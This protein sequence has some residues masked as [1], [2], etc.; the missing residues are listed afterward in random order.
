MLVG[1]AA[2]RA[3]RGAGVREVAGVAGESFLPL[4]EGL[5][6]ESVP[7]VHT[8]HESGAVFYAIG[9]ARIEGTPG[10]VAVT[11]GP[12]A[13]NAMIGIHEAYQSQTPLVLLVGQVEGR[14]RGRNVIQEMDIVHMFSRAAKATFEVPTP[15]R[16]APSLL[17]ALRTAQS[18]RPGP[19]VVSLP[20]DHL[21]A[22][23]DEVT[24]P[25][26]LTRPLEF[27]ALLPDATAA[28]I[29]VAMAAARSG[30]LVAGQRFGG[31]RE[32]DLLARAAA[33][34]GFGVVGGH[35]HIDVVDQQDPHWLSGA[36]VRS[37][38]FV[39][40]ALSE[41]D[42]VLL[43]GHS[44][45]D[46][47]SQG[48]ADI[49]GRIVS[50]GTGEFAT[51]DEYL[52][53]EAHLADPV[54]ALRQ[55]LSAFPAES[56]AR[57]ARDR[58]V[59]GLRDELTAERELVMGRNRTEAERG[60]PL[61]TVVDSLD[62]HLPDDVYVVSDVGTFNDWFVRYLPLRPGRRHIGPMAGPMGFALPTAL[63]VHRAARP[64]QTVVL[65]G[66]GGF[67]MTASELAT[68]ARLDENVTV[69]VFRNEVWG[70][71]AIH[72]DR[73][74]GIRYGTELVHVPDF[75]DLAQSFGV[76]G[77]RVETPDELD[78][79]LEKALSSPRPVLVEIFTDPVHLSPTYYTGV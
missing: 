56:P 10:V 65:A 73:E 22:Q 8:A 16:L 52:Q 33:A 54:L 4:L 41:A 26:V 70:S 74:Y 14:L 60:V 32:A 5:R 27:P 45:G 18:G 63:G 67:L 40:R 76:Q 57:S 38:G 39:R 75:G 34:T 55:I 9:R 61:A 71:I 11:R 43:L 35:S 68:L 29:A 64:A 20:T 1:H 79:T 6:R 36:T 49:P 46:R 25:P 3:L 7:F 48:Y 44:L 37:S 69:L 24:V 15:E 17:A 59:G 30:I 47:T 2:A 72:Q 13:S 62:A 50:L 77:L 28:E 21:Y 51:W 53:L 31:F 78:A 19:V 12:G 58:W 23:C 66:D 42:F